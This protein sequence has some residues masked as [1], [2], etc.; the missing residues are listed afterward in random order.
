MSFESQMSL[1]TYGQWSLVILWGVLFGLFIVFTPFYRKSQRRPTSIYLAFVVA[2]AF[3]MFGIPLSLYVVTWALGA[4]L[5]EGLLWGHT[6][7]PFIGDAAM[8]IGLAL[9][10]IGALLVI[11]GWKQIHT[12]Y[13]SK[14][15][16]QG[17]LVTNG[18]YAHSRHPQYA[19]FL[20]LS[21]GLLVHWATIP[22]LIM[23]PMLTVQ[24][25]R[26]AKK[27]EKEMEKQF[28]D[29]YTEYKRKTPMFIPFP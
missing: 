21:L 14:K 11:L 23:W 16:G 18:I 9:N 3:E 8:Y 4:S 25:Y 2:L 1:I 27:E 20:L 22:L 29:H 17:T 15:E 6:L 28:G 24:Y 10:L 5:P 26:L 7:T 12:Q 13:W 19:G